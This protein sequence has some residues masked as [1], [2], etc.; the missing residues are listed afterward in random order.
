M[1]LTPQHGPVPPHWMVYFAVGDCEA[2][3]KRAKELGGKVVVPP[4]DIPKAGRFSI[5]SDPAGAT[6]AI[7]KL[8]LAHQEPLATKAAA[9]QPAAPAKPKKK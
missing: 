1:E 9:T 6:F 4:T 8:N 5:L 7:I 2:S 3:S